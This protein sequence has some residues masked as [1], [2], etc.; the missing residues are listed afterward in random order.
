MESTKA[1]LDE[2]EVHTVVHIFKVDL[3]EDHVD[4][5]KHHSKKHQAKDMSLMAVITFSSFPKNEKMVARQIAK[6]A[7]IGPNVRGMTKAMKTET[8][9]RVEKGSSLTSHS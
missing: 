6:M 1:T 5:H 8:V 2:N 3:A 4:G 7:P 9:P